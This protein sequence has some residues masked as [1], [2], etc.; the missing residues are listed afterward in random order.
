MVIEHEIIY[1]FSLIWFGFFICGIVCMFHALN[2]GSSSQGTIAWCFSLLFFPIV[3]VI[4]YLLFGRNKFHRYAKARN[5]SDESLSY[6]KQQYFEKEEGSHQTPLRQQLKKLYE[7]FPD[8]QFVSSERLELL[9]NAEMAYP[10]MLKEIQNAKKYILLQ[11]FVIRDDEAGQTF[12]E[13]LIAKKDLDVY[14]LY[15]DIGSYALSNQ[16]VADLENAGIKVASFSAKKSLIT[17]RFQ[18]NFR[19]HRKILIVDG[20]CAFM[21]GLNIGDEYLGRGEK[22][23]YWRDTHLKVTGAAVNALQHAFVEDWYWSTKK[24]LE[25][26][27]QEPNEQAAKPLDTLVLTHGPDDFYG[28]GILTL[29]KF[30][31]SA[32]SRIWIAS[33]YFVPEPTILKALIGAALSGVDVRILLPQKADHLLVY[34]CSFAF[35]PIIEQSGIKIYRYQKGFM[36]QKIWLMDESVAAVGTTNLDNRSLVLNFEVM[37]IN[38]EQYFIKQVDAMLKEDFSNAQIENLQEFRYKPLYFRL[39]CNLSRL[40]SPLL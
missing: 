5:V 9:I 40:F 10:E 27:W 16:Y 7:K 31:Y 25:L 23:S 39:I 13:A 33:P 3:S 26:I 38:S 17:N 19:N 18:I 34:W 6:I 2:H 21:G 35:Y 15:D 36:H 28:L 20:Q 14:L 32:K 24:I 1:L 30:I 4:L 22:F 29:S 12:K 8:R 11:S 37:L